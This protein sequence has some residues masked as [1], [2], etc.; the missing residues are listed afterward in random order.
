MPGVCIVTNHFLLRIF[1]L[2]VVHNLFP[3][4]EYSE[5]AMKQIIQHYK[6]EAE[7]LNIQKPISLYI[8]KYLI[9]L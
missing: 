7:D 3:L 8:V 6:D 2:H 4:N 9:K 5:G 1:I